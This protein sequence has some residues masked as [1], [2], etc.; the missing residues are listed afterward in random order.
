M[1]RLR[2]LASAPG[3]RMEVEV[4]DPVPPRRRAVL[5]D[6]SPLAAHRYEAVSLRWP[7]LTFFT[8]NHQGSELRLHVVGSREEPRSLDDPVGYLQFPHLSPTEVCFDT[9]TQERINQ[10]FYRQDPDEALDPVEAFW[11]TNVEDIH[12]PMLAAMKGEVTLC[13]KTTATWSGDT[14]GG[15]LLHPLRRIIASAAYSLVEDVEFSE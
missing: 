10:R 1:M 11:N 14:V 2:W 4:F 9:E 12:Y 15:D 7:W 6:V 5:A 13:R 3:E 8:V